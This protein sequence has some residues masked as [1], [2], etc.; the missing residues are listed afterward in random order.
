MKNPKSEIKEA[1]VT[2]PCPS[3]EGMLNTALAF[4]RFLNEMKFFKVEGVHAGLNES[5]PSSEGRAK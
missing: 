5:I 1:T 4:R 2:H 3:Q